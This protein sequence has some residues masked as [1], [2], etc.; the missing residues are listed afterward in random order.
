M[1][2]LQRRTRIRNLMLKCIGLELSRK[3]NALIL[4]IV[5]L[6]VIY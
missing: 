1:C 4:N 5:T 6:Y 3:C 2:L